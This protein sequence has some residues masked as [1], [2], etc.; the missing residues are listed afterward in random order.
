MFKTF[1]TSMTLPAHEIQ[2]TVLEKDDSPAF[3]YIL[4]PTQAHIP[5]NPTCMTDFLLPTAPESFI[6]AFVASNHPLSR[7]RVDIASSDPGKEI[8]WDPKYNDNPLDEETLAGGVQFVERI[9]DPR[10]PLGKLLKPGG[11]RLLEIVADTAEKAK[12]I[13]WRRRISL[14]HVSG[15]CAMMLREKGGVTD[16][17]KSPRREEVASG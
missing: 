5:E 10:A 16:G 15:T 9:I 13:I 7:G 4:F 12:E 14:F 1:N 3:Q 11:R 2:R 17:T 6:S 8:E